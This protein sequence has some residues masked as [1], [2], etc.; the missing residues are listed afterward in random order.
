M[1]IT[2]QHNHSYVQSCP[3]QE[4]TLFTL[5]SPACQYEV[6][7]SIEKSRLSHVPIF[8]CAMDT[9]INSPFT[10]PRLLKCT[11]IARKKTGQPGQ[12]QRLTRPRVRALSQ[13]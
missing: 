10:L 8:I 9:A 2:K 13:T 12:L 4:A 6:Q 11:C 5:H 3:T 1:C 7:N